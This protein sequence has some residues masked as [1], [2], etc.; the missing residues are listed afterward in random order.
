MALLLS[1]RLLTFV[2]LANQARQSVLERKALKKIYL[3]KKQQKLQQ[4][5]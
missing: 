4:P 1:H 3:I 2:A 5:V